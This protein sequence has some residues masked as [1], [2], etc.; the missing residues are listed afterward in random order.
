MLERLE[1]LSLPSVQYT[2]MEENMRDQVMEIC[3]SACDTHA[4]NNEKD[5][6]GLQFVPKFRRLLKPNWIPSALATIY[7][8]L[9]KKKDSKALE[10]KQKERASATM[11]IDNSYE[12]HCAATKRSMPG[13]AGKEFCHFGHRTTAGMRLFY[14]GF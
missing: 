10:K 14:E 12:A 8:L 6:F 13:R 7:E 3:N 4:E 9:E 1:G 5:K 11:D 2:D